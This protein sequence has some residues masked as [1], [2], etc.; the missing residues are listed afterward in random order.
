MFNPFQPSIE[1]TSTMSAPSGG[2]NGFF[3]SISTWWGNSATQPEQPPAVESVPTDAPE[4]SNAAKRA[5][6]AQNKY[7]VD[8]A[9]SIPRCSIHPHVIKLREVD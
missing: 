8:V 4:E 5:R 6:L 3:S 7:A 9:H 1:R 2:S